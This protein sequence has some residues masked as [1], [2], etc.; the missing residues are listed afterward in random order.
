MR[1]WPSD[2]AIFGEEDVLSDDPGVLGEGRLRDGG[3]RVFLARNGEW[4][5]TKAHWL[6]ELVTCP[7]CASAY[8]STFVVMSEAWWPTV[9]HPIALALAFS[10]LTGL[11]A[12]KLDR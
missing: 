2:D 9:W 8:L 5:A 11:I 10:G 6:G 3:A 1:R 4:M 12:T 7:W